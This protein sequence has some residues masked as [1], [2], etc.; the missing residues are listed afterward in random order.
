M[1]TELPHR[2]ARTDLEK[3]TPPSVTPVW[4]G[5][6]RNTSPASTSSSVPSACVILLD[7]SSS[8][9]QC[10]LGLPKSPLSV[11][12]GCTGE[13]RLKV[14]SLGLTTHP[15][16]MP[17]ERG[18]IDSSR[19]R[20]PVMRR[21]L[22][23]ACLV[24]VLLIPASSALADSSGRSG[25]TIAT[26]E[27]PTPANGGDQGWGNCGHNSSGG[28]AH[29]GDN[30]NGGGNGGDAKTSCVTDPTGGGTPPPQ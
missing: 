20:P 18:S 9:P 12:T 21:T 11:P 27:A 3:V 24:G 13:A 10:S 7:P 26:P 30:G 1:L 16:R 5:G 22:T 19:W 14:H 23:T 6:Q 15:D 8:I 25:G 17:M 4:P 2:A 29:T 28:N